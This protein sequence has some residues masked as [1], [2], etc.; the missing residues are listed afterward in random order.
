MPSRIVI[1]D[2][3]GSLSF[4]VMDWLASQR[5]PLIRIGWRGE[6][7]AVLG[8]LGFAADPKKVAAQLEAKRNGGALGIATDLIRAK[9]ANSVEALRHAVPQSPAREVALAKITLDAASLGKRQPPSIGE[10]LG[11]EGR[12]ANAYFAAWHGLPIHW[13]GIGRKPIPEAWHWVERRSTSAKRKITN[14]NASHPVNA[15]LSPG[16]QPGNEPGV[17]SG[18]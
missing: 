4:D 8:T 1:L 14:R 12:V 3:S 17:A 13:K 16:P 10:L 6:V 9:V 18:N 7:Q 5:V 15:M 11:I 2:G